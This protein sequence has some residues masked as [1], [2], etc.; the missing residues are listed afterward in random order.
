MKGTIKTL[1]E[2]GFGFITGEGMSKDLF[3]HRNALV[4]VEF[5]D[6][7]EGDTVTFETED[8]PK[9]MNAV[10]VERV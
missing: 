6:L 10:N 2:N 4:N 9:G 8:S 7:R 3:F 1:K 5:N